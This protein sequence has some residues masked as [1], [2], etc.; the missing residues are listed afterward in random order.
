MVPYQTPIIAEK[1]SVI[2][3]TWKVTV[4]TATHISKT[5]S[6]TPMFYI[7]NVISSPEWNFLQSLK[8]VCEAD[9]EPP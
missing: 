5:N 2:L 9:S 6:V 7:W 4:A 3:V 8:K 1:D